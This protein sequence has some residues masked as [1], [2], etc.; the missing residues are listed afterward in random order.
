MLKSAPY[1]SCGTVEISTMDRVR[2]KI[3]ESEPWTESILKKEISTMDRVPV[4]IKESAPWA[5]FQSEEKNQHL[6][7]SPFWRKKSVPWTELQ[8]KKRDQHL[9][10]SNAVSRGAEWCVSAPWTES[11]YARKN[12]KKCGI[13][14]NSD[15]Y[16][17]ISSALMGL[18]WTM[19]TFCKVDS[20]ALLSQSSVWRLQFS[21]LTSFCF[22]FSIE[23][24]W[25]LSICSPASWAVLD[26][27]SGNWRLRNESHL[28][29]QTM[30]ECERVARWCRL[31]LQWF[32]RVSRL[33]WHYIQTN[34]LFAQI[35]SFLQPA[36]QP[37]ESQ[38]SK[39]FFSAFIE[40][41]R[42]LLSEQMDCFQHLEL[43]NKS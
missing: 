23:F 38:R 12:G 31:W 4:R 11:R 21:M 3:N 25:F 26:S 42:A 30:L 9:G 24:H 2:D 10:Q 15:F 18:F 29:H 1:R 16:I 35:K 27:W 8:L 33:K 39:S 14:P 28:P 7:Q 20:S 43:M 32:P 6:G 37:G 41:I 40:W 19:K 5:E 13:F 22:S 34:L 17:I 36:Y